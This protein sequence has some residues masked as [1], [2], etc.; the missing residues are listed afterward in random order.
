TGLLPACTTEVAL[1]SRGELLDAGPRERVFTTANLT[2]LYGCPIEVI[3]MDGRH[4]AAAATSWDD[5]RRGHP[6]DP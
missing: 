2:R 4:H 1:V 5:L 3:A 6:S